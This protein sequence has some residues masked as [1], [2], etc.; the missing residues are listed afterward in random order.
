M[1]VVTVGGKIVGSKRTMVVVLAPGT[2]YE[3]VRLAEEVV[4]LGTGRKPSTWRDDMGTITVCDSQKPVEVGRLHA[5]PR[6]SDARQ[7]AL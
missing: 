6:S 5:H 7:E 4:Q 1:A 2:P 3:D